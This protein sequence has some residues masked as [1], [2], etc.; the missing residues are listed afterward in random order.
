MARAVRK[1]ALYPKEG[2]GEGGNENFSFRKPF[3]PL[4]SIHLK[5]SLP[6]GTAQLLRCFHL[7]YEGETEVIA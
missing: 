6:T 5:V 2:D 7:K 1:P 3:Q 4:L